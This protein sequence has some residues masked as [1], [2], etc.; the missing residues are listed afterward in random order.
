M[1]ARAS[2]EAVVVDGR[3]TIVGLRS[4]PPL[5][6][7]ETTDAVYLVG[8]AAGPLG[9]DDLRID[10]NVDDGAQLTVRS[11]AATLAHPGPRGGRSHLAAVF[12][13]GQGATLRWRP[14]PLVSVRG[15][16]HTVDTTVT[17]RSE[18]SFVMQDELVLGRDNESSGRVRSR[19]RL[20]RDGAPLLSHDLDVGGDAPGWTSAAVLGSARAV[21]S[22]VVVGRDAPTEARS[23]VDREAGARAA[24]LPLAP[25]AAVLLALA[26]GLRAARAAAA[27]LTSPG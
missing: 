9:G 6:V 19:L 13:V 3:T 16:D 11:A 23:L 2:I 7:R 12:T 24:W 26:P 10:V 1:R 22:I 15:S 20:Q 4:E 21:V 27:A 18:S 5:V 17:L 25:R 14:E 8:A